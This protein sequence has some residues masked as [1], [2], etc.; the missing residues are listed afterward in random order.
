MRTTPALFLLTALA[1]C[2][3][4]PKRAITDDP[5][6]GAEL[7]IVSMIRIQDT[8]QLKRGQWALYS[9]RSKESPATMA[10]R[11]AVVDAGD[12]SYWIE[13]R[14]TAPGPSGQ[15][16]VIQKY[17]IDSTGKTLQLWA[18]VMPSERPT[19][20]FPGKDAMGNPVEAPKVADSDAKAQVDIARERITVDATGK[21]FDCTRLTSKV[22]YPD[23][24]ETTLVTWCSPDVPFA[25]IHDG[26]NYGGVV[27]RTYGQ[28]TLELQMKGND[29][30]A[31]LHLPE[32]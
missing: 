19:K 28:F 23:G 17:Q 7:A 31:E 16:T 8:A 10:T 25:V 27:R 20:V 2:A 9:I 32:K 22:R 21:P 11:L 12:D 1:A 29:A 5:H 14:T 13:N 15:Q 30:V 24:R 18:A 26:K 4:A 6:K 3:P